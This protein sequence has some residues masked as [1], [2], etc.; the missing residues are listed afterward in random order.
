[1]SGEE[2]PLVCL[3]AGEP[4]GDLL[5]GRLMTALNRIEY[6]RVRFAGIGGE[7]MGAAGLHSLFPMQE[8]SVMGLVEVLPRAP[9][10]LRRIAQT[11]RAIR[12]M[13]PDAVITIDAPGFCFRLAKRLKGSG[14]PLI[15]YVAPSV[16]AWR[17]GRAV[18]VAA[19]YDHLLTLLPWEPP[20]FERH[21]LA[22][23][24][25]GHPAVAEAPPSDG[26]AFRQRHG[27]AADA[28]LLAVLP[29]SRQGEVSRLLPLF[30]EALGHLTASVQRLH[31]VVTTVPATADGV[32]EATAHW[33]LPATITDAAER[34]DAFAAANA[35]VAASGTVS[36]ELAATRTPMVVCYRMA[37]L[38]MWV[39]KR[40][41][42]IP[43]ISLVNLALDEAAVPELIQEDCTAGA[44]AAAAERL[45][46]DPTARET[47]IA[48]LEKGVALLGAGATP[49][50]SA[51]RAVLDVIA[52][53]PIPEETTN[54]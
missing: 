47:Q 42:R 27:I 44:I 2:G 34:A 24:F 26:Q 15:H 29:G 17:P 49:S 25:V 9:R 7:A 19:L 10:L 46:V 28:P 20:Y 37:P 33:P 36:V 16:W 14:I 39:A 32:A 13:A 11:E 5:G 31:A 23:T 30:G 3:V 18:R 50:E 48:A 52:A 51:A 12:D 43:Y 4:S 6:G 38:T 8:L 53:R 1:V 41:V 21:G 22:C 40:L 54:G 35:A 45:L